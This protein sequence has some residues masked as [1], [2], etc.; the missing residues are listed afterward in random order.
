MKPIE[1]MYKGILFRSRLEARWA[2]FMDCLEIPWD[3]EPD[4][5][6][7]AKAG[8]YVPD[9]WL[10]TCECFAEVKPDAERITK[11]ET[12]KMRATGECLFLPAPPAFHY[13]FKLTPEPKEIPFVFM[14]RGIRELGPYEEPVNPSQ[15]P[16]EYHVAVERAWRAR[17]DGY[18]R[19]RW[20]REQR[21]A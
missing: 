11:L 8:K 13:Y 10:S 3:Y 7:A 6:D 14:W 18:D 15:F 21:Y 1:T 19:D 17:F 4:V 2:V 12:D 20:E 16:P 5:I 9:F